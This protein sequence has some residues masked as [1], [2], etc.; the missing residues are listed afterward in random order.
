MANQGFEI[1]GKTRI[2]GIIADPIHH[3]K[4]PQEMNRLLAEHSMD[5][6]MVPF[7]TSANNLKDVVD[8]LRHVQSL[9]GFIVTVP[10]KNAIVALCDT[11]TPAAKMVGAVNVVRRTDKGLHGDILDGVGFV[12]GLRKAGI[13]PKGMS[14]YLAG[15]GG[16]AHA[17]AFALAEKG[18]RKL[19]IANRTRSKAEELCLRL[20]DIFRDVEF[21]AGTENPADHE[22][23]IN[24]TSMG[25]AEDDPYPLNV[26]ELTPD[27]IV[28]EIIMQ[29]VKTK[30]LEFAES[31]GC[32]VHP[33]L[34]MLQCQIEYMAI[35]MG[36]DIKNNDKTES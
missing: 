31:R 28:A 3:V 30:L 14:V 13:D 33:G 7:H 1:T 11:L 34:P 18:V 9:D 36:L 17:I 21:Q 10:H 4:T 20:A 19:T 12:A 26:E 25:L 32:R 2:C 15:A 24:S 5:C 27:Q 23:V 16:A 29:P 8:G 22:L 6:L 35:A